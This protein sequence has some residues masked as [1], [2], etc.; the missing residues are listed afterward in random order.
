MLLEKK[1]DYPFL[2]CP[3]SPCHN[4]KTVWVRVTSFSY[5][6]DFF[7]LVDGSAQ[8]QDMWYDAEIVW[9]GVFRDL[10]LTFQYW[11]YYEL[12]GRLDLDGWSTFS[13]QLM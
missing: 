8:A 11:H 10:I 4:N 9:L 1:T 12:A 13:L 6:C 7:G 3:L 5:D 2:G